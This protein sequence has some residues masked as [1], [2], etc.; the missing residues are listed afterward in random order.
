M[1]TPEPA[2]DPDD[3]SAP[4]ALWAAGR[5]FL[6]WLMALF[7]APHDVAAL[8]VLTPKERSEILGWLRPVEALVRLLLIAEAAAL[9]RPAPPSPSSLRPEPRRSAAERPH[10]EPDPEDSRRWP[11]RFRVFVARGSKRRRDPSDAGRRWDDHAPWLDPWPVAR[12]IEAVR[13][14]LEDASPYARRL[15]RRLAAAPARAEPLISRARNTN[16]KRRQLGDE[17]LGF[18]A[19][20]AAAALAHFDTS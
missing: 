19:D 20:H 12:R 13:R 18:A 15:A 2:F 5:Y 3:E 6:D 4:P 14:V 10:A 11:T 9:P 17:A 8:G 7:G 1:T 16:R